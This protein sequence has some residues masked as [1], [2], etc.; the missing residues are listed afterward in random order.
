MIQKENATADVAGT[1]SEKIMITVEHGSDVSNIIDN[2]NDNS[3]GNNKVN[4]SQV[5]VKEQRDLVLN[6]KESSTKNSN[7]SNISNISNNSNNISNLSNNI[8]DNISN[9]SNNSNE[10]SPSSNRCVSSDSVN[11]IVSVNVGVNNKFEEELPRQTTAEKEKSPLQEQQHQ[12]QR[13]EQEQEQEVSVPVSAD[14]DGDGDGDNDDKDRSIQKLKLPPIPSP[15]QIHSKS[16]PQ[17]QPQPQAPTQ[18]LAQQSLTFEE[19]TDTNTNANANINETIQ[20]GENIAFVDPMDTDG[21]AVVEGIDKERSLQKFNLSPIPPTNTNTDSNTIANEMSLEDEHMA[22]SFVDPMD[23]LMCELCTK[24]DRE[25]EMLICDEC[26]RGFHIFCFNPP[27]KK[28]PKVRV[29]VICV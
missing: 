6:L 2:E 7:T 3:N 18:S 20:E 11:I 10:I 1:I 26:D 27:I 12:Q 23:V 19:K 24:G 8:S 9:N 13:Q 15:Q 17:P 29:F 28:I 21:D 14:G 4:N 22:S 5:D 25:T 16:Q